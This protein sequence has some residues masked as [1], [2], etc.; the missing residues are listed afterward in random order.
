MDLYI[1]AQVVGIE[2]LL[3]L[4][5]DTAFAEIGLADEA[6]E[7]NTLSILSLLFGFIKDF[8]QLIFIGT[9]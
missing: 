4:D 7:Q 5:T 6:V 3:N 8:V 9:V 1:Q 2:R